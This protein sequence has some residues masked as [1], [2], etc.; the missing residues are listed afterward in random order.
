M[1]NDIC[2]IIEITN[3]DSLYYVYNKRIV[4]H[5]SDMA[6][7]FTTMKQAYN[8]YKNSEY[9]KGEQICRIVKYNKKTDQII[10]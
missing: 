7:K 1:D 2:Y 5:N 6:K 3:D 10:Y 4:L 8:Y 9:Y